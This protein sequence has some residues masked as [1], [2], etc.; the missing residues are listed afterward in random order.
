MAEVRWIKIVTDIFDDE[1]ILLIETLP[2]ADSIIVIWF[3]LLCLAGKQNNSGV[4]MLND[5]I[6]YNEKMFATIFRRKESTVQLAFETFANFGMIEIIDGAVTIPNW[7]KHQSLDQLEERKE[8]MRNYMRDYR[9][10]QKQLAEGNKVPENGLPLKEWKK[11]LDYF[12]NECAY[13]G[14]RDTEL[15]QEHIIPVSKGGKYEMGNII[16]AC[17][18][19]NSSKQNKNIHEWYE[20]QEF[21]ND[22]KLNKIENFCK[23]YNVNLRKANVNSL[24]KIRED[25]N[26]LDKNKEKSRFVPPSLDEVME[27]CL[28]R[29][30]QVDPQTF[31]DFYESKGWM[32]GKNK[33]KDWKAAVRTW[34]KRETKTGNPFKEALR[35]ELQ[36]E[37]SGSNGNNGGYQG[38]LSKLLQEPGR[39]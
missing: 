15:E 4:F 34:E 20:Q 6:P 8:Y 2:E 16:P 13:C 1:K 3:K 14:E 38:G 37:Q 26:R 32:I 35:K 5:R 25:K 12:D 18:S 22:L 30:N 17:R 36:N 19:C 33:M 29:N 31:I 7:G 21:Y 11:V 39:D 28:T 24:D 23:L 10:K 27:Y 9:K